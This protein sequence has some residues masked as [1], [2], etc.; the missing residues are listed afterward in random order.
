MPS[1]SPSLHETSNAF[2]RDGSHLR[3]KPRVVANDVEMLQIMAGH[4]AG[5]AFIPRPSMPP[6]LDVAADLQP[7]LPELVGC[8]RTF[9]IVVPSSMRL[10]PKIRVLVEMTER[11]MARPSGNTSPAD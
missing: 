10:V 5:L 11:I 6:P 2:L 3:I 8:S 7:V 1:A 9:A 4:S